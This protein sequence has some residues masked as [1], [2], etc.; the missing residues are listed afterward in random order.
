M[1]ALN[2]KSRL[3]YLLVP[4]ICLSTA[5]F[6][7]FVTPTFGQTNS[8]SYSQNPRSP[9][10]VSPA[11]EYFASRRARHAAAAQRYSAT[12]PAPASTSQQVQLRGSKPFQHINRG[13]ALSPYLNLDRI[14]SGTGLPNYYAFVQP[15]IEQRETNRAQSRELRR[16]EQQVRTATAPRNRSTLSQG[17]MP[18]TGNSNQFLNL[19]NYYPGLR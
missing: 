13:S 8:G 4:S 10:R 5:F 17:G 1:E 3:D 9:Q 14:E 12:R 7:F 2:T 6:A 15:L 11:L 18:T 19:D 16:L